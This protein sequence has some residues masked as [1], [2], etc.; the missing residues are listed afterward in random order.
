VRNDF[1]TA[2]EEFPPMYTTLISTAELAARLAAPDLVV[3]DVR[4]D[5][6]QPD[7]WGEAQYREGHVPGA[8][9]ARS[10]RCRSR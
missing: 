10:R 2:S 8:R 6:A 5:L 9:S 7:A 4:H 3:V 1:V